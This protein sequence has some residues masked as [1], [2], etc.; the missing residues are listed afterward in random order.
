MKDDWEGYANLHQIIEENKEDCPTV[1]VANVEVTNLFPSRARMF[2]KDR[3]GKLLWNQAGSLSSQI[4]Q[5][6]HL[7]GENRC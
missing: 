7:L 1:D 2:L 4:T 5:K 6:L 3:N